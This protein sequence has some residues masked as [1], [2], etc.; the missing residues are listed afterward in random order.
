MSP[1]FWVSFIFFKV[2]PNIKPRSD[3]IALPCK[4]SL[5]IEPFFA[6]SPGCLAQPQIAADTYL[7]LSLLFFSPISAASSLWTMPRASLQASV[8]SL[9]EKQD[10]RFKL[11][12]LFLYSLFFLLFNPFFLIWGCNQDSRICFVP[13]SSTFFPPL[14]SYPF[15]PV[16]HSILSQTTKENA[17]RAL[18]RTVW[19]IYFKSYLNFVIKNKFSEWEEP[20]VWISFFFPSNLCAFGWI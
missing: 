10:N 5:S 17:Q 7:D 12:D 13:N 3:C 2:I 1:H 19:R 18:A 4:V 20:V 11:K 14:F 8:T 16:Q 15:S 6:G 9:L